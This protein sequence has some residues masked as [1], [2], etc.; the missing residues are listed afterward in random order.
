MRRTFFTGN[1][2]QSIS[3]LAETGKDKGLFFVKMAT[4][5][6]FDLGFAFNLER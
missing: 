1:G 5:F 3:H 4:T 2:N 6:N